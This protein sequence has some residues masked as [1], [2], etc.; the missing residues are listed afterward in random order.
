MEPNIERAITRL[1]EAIVLHE[2][3]MNGSAPTTGPAGIR[4]QKEMMRMMQ[5]ALSALK[6]GGQNELRNLM[7]GRM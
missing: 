4:S 1:R 3:H 2:K 7:R 6:S 5:D